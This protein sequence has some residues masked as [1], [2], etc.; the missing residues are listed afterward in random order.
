M[1]GSTIVSTANRS[2]TRGVLES[3]AKTNKEIS[4]REGREGGEEKMRIDIGAERVAVHN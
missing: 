4:C 2:N 1:S 3:Y